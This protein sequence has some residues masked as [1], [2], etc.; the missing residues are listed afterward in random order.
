MRHNDY[1]GEPRFINLY[2]LIKI[3]FVMKEFSCRYIL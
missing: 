3:L 2:S 1:W